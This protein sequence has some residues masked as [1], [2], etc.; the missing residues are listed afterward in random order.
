MANEAAPDNLNAGAERLRRLFVYNGGFLTQSRIRRIL[1]L[2]GYRVTLGKPG[3]G[4]MVGVW[5]QSPTAPRGQAVAARTGAPILRVEDAFLRSILPGRAGGGPPLGLMLDTNGVHF[6]P[7]TPSDLENL[8]A[9]HPLDDTA[10][11]NRARDASARLHELHLTKYTGFDPALPAPDPGYVVVVDQ[12]AGDASV[13][14]TG[15]GEA[16]FRE[17]LAFAQIE[18]P[19]ARIL[20]RTHPET[21][22]GKRVGHFTADQA[23]GNIELFDDPVSPWTLLDGAVAVYTYSSQLGFEA[24]LAGHKPRVF[25]QPFYGGWGLTQDEAPVPRRERRLTRAQIF[26]AAMILAPKWYDPFRDELCSLERA[27]DILD[28][29]TRAWRDD[30][31]GWQARHIRLWKRPHMQRFF[32][33]STPVRFLR[34]D[35]PTGARE[36]SWAGKTAPEAHVT[37]V[38]DGFLRSRGLGAALVPPLSLV[39]DDL[40]IYYDPSRRSRVERLIERRQTLTD[41]QRTR[42]INLITRLRR[43]GATKYNLPGRPLPNLPA[44]QVILVPGQVEDDASIRLGCGAE[45]TNRALLERARAE[46]PNAIIAYKPH[47]DVEAGLRPGAVDAQRLADLVLTDVP[48]DA[49]LAAADA[50]WTLTS[51]MGFEALVRGLPVTTLGAPFYAGWGLTRDLGPVPARRSA[52]PDLAGLVH[53]TLIDYPRYLDPVTGRPCPVEVALDRLE[54]GKV[55]TGGPLNRLLAKAQGLLASRAHLWR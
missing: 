27:I 35:A 16:Q 32:G 25:G 48:A 4:D 2:S 18:N 50:V 53:A 44:G 20:I 46:N 29:E 45:A 22:A 7:T 30:H 38:E 28:A 41:A 47:P 40:G 39:L 34:D 23:T 52:R 33:A 6:D 49:A 55:Y 43:T 5:G 10:L 36:M 51:L 12:T 31:A 13:T 21:R 17:M 15:G 54:S 24:I 3:A 37:R 42:A 8:L 14:A 1:A 9:T 19:G 26:A 11:L